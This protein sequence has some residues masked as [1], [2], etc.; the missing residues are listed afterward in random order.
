MSFTLGASPRRI[1]V[2]LVSV[3]GIRLA[4][5]PTR[6]VPLLG[7]LLAAP[8]HAPA[9]AP[10]YSVIRRIAVP[11]DG[12]WDDLTADSR[13]RRLYISHSTRVQVLDLDRESLIGE[14]PDTP[15]VHGIAL[16]PDLGRGFASNGRDSSVTVF[17]LKTL[18]TVARIKLPARNPDAILYDPASGRVFT[19]NGGSRSATAIDA[20][21]G[22][23]VGTIE[24][25][26][27]PEF[28]VT[29]SAGR[30]FVNLEDSSAVLMF[31]SKALKP[32]ARWPLAPAVNPS[33][34]ALD[35]RHHRLF[36]VCRNHLMAVLDAENGRL[37]DTLAI[38]GGV[39]G[40]AFD[41]ATGL[42]F[43]SNGEGTLTMVYEDTPDHFTWIANVP[44]EYG[45]R[46]LAVDRKTHHVYLATAQFGPAPAATVENPYP[47][48][49]VI[50][51]SF[52]ILVVAPQ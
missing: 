35:A 40:V 49:P 16:A 20:A 1:A 38:G 30:I 45:A 19:F 3:L 44:T 32:L 6:G 48:R 37:V 26:G 13:S 46:T 9:P 2:P 52:V 17:D 7:L 39:D 43:S 23:I 27:R 42:V 18:A 36:S 50:P 29:D 12:G 34:L 4:R 21:S 10:H 25:G 47:R 24:L 41:P 33:G 28:A 14:I 11:G 51:G 5:I 15:G 8:H 22:A 31:D